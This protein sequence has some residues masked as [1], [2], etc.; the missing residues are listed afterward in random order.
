MHDGEEAHIAARSLGVT[1]WTV[2][3]HT[4]FA[5]DA[6]RP[7]TPRG[8][9]LL[10]HELTHTRQA[11]ANLSRGIVFGSDS[12]SGGRY[13]ATEQADMHAGR[14]EGD[15]NDVR[16]ATRLE[17]HEGDIVF[18]LGSQQL[19]ERIGEP[20]THG[21]IYLGGGLIH[22]MVGFGN[23]DVR[24][25]DFFAE[26][27]DPSVVK[28]IRF[29]G[30]LADIIVPRVVYNIRNRILDLPTDPLPWNLFSSALDY[31]TATCLEYSHA[32]FLN[33]IRG[34]ST[35]S[36]WSDDVL[37][38]LMTT[39]FDPTGLTPQPLI[40]PRELVVEGAMGIAVNE[41]R[42]LMAAADYLADDVDPRVFEN[43]WEGREELKQIAP[44]WGGLGSFWQQEILTSFTYRSF[45]E[46]TR[47]FTVVR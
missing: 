27:A 38:D 47:F 15:S 21:G 9:A 7:G 24:V 44:A 2:G 37:E 41:R 33:A 28:V 16:L 46:A 26:A 13:T 30:P 42:G 29:T 1:A 22:D 40:R 35:E 11:E 34:I 6:P 20:V 12:S 10:R 18:R 43:R 14:V 39:Y 8:D 23:R 5:A 19:A 31:R 32:Q 4:G 45:T 25:S 36:V 3:G 17:F